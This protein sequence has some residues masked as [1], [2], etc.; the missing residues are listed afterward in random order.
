M[1]SAESRSVERGESAGLPKLGISSVVDGWLTIA[2]T[3]LM[4]QNLMNTELR[5][6]NPGVCL[7]A[8]DQN[9][10]LDQLKLHG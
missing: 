9:L 3:L 7:K 4:T 5:Q 2:I 10:T 8:S 6:I 1:I